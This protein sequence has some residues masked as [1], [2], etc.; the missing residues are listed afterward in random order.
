MITPLYR[1]TAIIIVILLFLGVPVIP[2]LALTELEEKMQELEEITEAIE[3]YERLYEQKKKEEG[4]VLGQIRSLDNN[5]DRL[6]KEIDT[7]NNKITDTTSSIEGTQLDINRVSTQIDERTAY[8]QKRVRY[9][10]QEG[11]VGYLEVLLQSTSL[12]DFLT[13]FD[14]M[15]KIAENDERILKESEADRNVL[16]EKKNQLEEKVWELYQFKGQQESKQEQMEIQHRQKNNYLKTI[17]EQAGEFKRSSQALEDVRKQIDDFI[18]EWQEKHSQGYLG[19]GKMQ[20]PVPG[21]TVITS[22]FG[23]RVHPIFKVKRYHPAIDIRAP[24]GTTIEASER[25]KVIYAGNKGGYGK[26]IIIDHGGSVSTQYSHLWKFL[27]S[28][29]EEVQKGQAIAKADS[30]GWST[31]S[32]LDFII[33]VKGEPQN[34]TLYVSP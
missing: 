3:K 13:R 23:W 4:Q 15:E 26:A 29:G 20:W 11:N 28:I 25:G 14:F 19:S 33:R 12:T 32:H 1:I 5:I 10:Y 22:D 6:E 16:M 18:R 2:L 7:L 34:P 21:Q 24:H 31:G 8:L 30:T 27:V 17:Q 9:I